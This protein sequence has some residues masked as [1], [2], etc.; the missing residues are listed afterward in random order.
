MP[1]RITVVNDNPEFLELL[2]DILEDEAYATTTVDG[3]LDD[4]LER[5]I[6]SQPDLLIVDLRMGTDQLHGW[7]VAQQVRLEPALAALPV[8]ICSADVVALQELAE[9]LAEAKS[10]LTLTKPFAIEELTRAIDS[11]LTEAA[12]T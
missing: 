2:D 12:T 1:P 10:V 8:I 4:A 7:E 5:I 6:M 9:D 3:D 11:L